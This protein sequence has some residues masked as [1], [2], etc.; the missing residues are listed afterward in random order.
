MD[1][2][3]W[4]APLLGFLSTLPYIGPFLATAAG[5][6]T[7]VSA[8][9]TAFTALW[10]AVVKILEAVALVPGAQKAQDA[11]DGLKDTGEKVDGIL[12]KVL[13]V[14]SYLNLLPV[15]TKTPPVQDPPAGQ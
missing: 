9:I 6:V 12:G 7:G 3:G 5:Y 4:I 11:A 13:V 2:L 10:H 14:L 1:D 15:P 8:V